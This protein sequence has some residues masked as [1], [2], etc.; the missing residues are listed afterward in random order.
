V[1]RVV[2]LLLPGLL[3]WLLP[4][5]L[6]LQLR[7]KHNAL[8]KQCAEKLCFSQSDKYVSL[9]TKLMAASYDSKIGWDKEQVPLPKDG[10]LSRDDCRSTWQACCRMMS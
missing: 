3:L 1:L 2:L 6:R 8:A 7:R 4:V 10:E 9:S 5:L